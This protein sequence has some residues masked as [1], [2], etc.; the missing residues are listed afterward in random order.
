ME[1][2]F[3]GLFASAMKSF[4]ESIFFYYFKVVAAFVVVVLLIADLLLLA[5]RVRKDVRIAVYGSSAPRIRKTEYVK[6]WEAIQRGIEE[7]S[8]AAGKIA[9]I[10][11]DRMLGEVLGKAGYEG[12]DTGE[13]LSSVKAGQ[14]EGAHEASESHKICQRIIEDPTYS[15]DQG[16]LREALSGYEK[17]FRGLGVID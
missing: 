4:A 13:K 11:A 5:K 15:I 16:A 9:L 2:D 8:I 10:E 1:L 12:K 7:G 6:K 17:V 3:A 14:L